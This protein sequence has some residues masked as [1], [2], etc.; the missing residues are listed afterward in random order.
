MNSAATTNSA[1]RTGAYTL[2]DAARLLG[3]PLSRLR[4][5]VRGANSGDD[6]EDRRHP[7]G[8]FETF[9]EGRDRYFN[10]LTLIELFTIA[11][12]RAH[13]VRMKTL[14][15]SRAELSK[16]FETAHPLALRGLLTDGQKL[17]K[18]LGDDL[19]LELGTGGQTALQKLVEP[20]CH[21]LD[22]DSTTK[23]A[24][25]FYPAG[26]DA[27]VIVDPLHSFGRPV[28]AGTNITTEALGCLI[29]GGEKIEDVA[30][31]FQLEPIQ[32]EQAWE[33]ERKLAA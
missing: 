30:A 2:P 3:V 27:S 10:F 8:A 19:L 14:R 26:R 23:L 1:F 25:R 11:Q 22:F 21:R 5:W 6:S 16:R 20:F 33:F 15:E 13:G 31:D 18:E 28:I 24:A 7:A 4:V 9:S 12:L 32:V 17:L 29:R